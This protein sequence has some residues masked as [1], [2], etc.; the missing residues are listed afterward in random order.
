MPP[1]CG[2]GMDAILPIISWCSGEH[3]ALKWTLAAG[4]GEQ[5]AERCC[6]APC[7]E[8]Q[9]LMMPTEVTR[10]RNVTD[11]EA[12]ALVPPRPRAAGARPRGPGACTRAAHPSTGYHGAPATPPPAW[13]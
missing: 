3:R 8:G 13:A 6:G 2:L 1:R 4:Q 11:I 10:A 7:P 5:H 12:R 9:G